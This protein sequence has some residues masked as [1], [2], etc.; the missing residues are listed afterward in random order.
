MLAAV[1]RSLSSQ[2]L[3]SQLPSSYQLP[4]SCPFHPSLDLL[5]HEDGAKVRVAGT[6]WKC[7]RCNRVFRTQ[8]YV[9]QHIQNRHMQHAPQVGTGQASESDGASDECIS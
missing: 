2:L 7:L 8:N 3:L 5:V 6:M 9:D 4:T 1:P